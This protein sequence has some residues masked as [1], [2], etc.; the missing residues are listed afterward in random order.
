MLISLY[1]D[2]FDQLTP[3]VREKIF[4]CSKCIY[5]KQKFDDCDCNEVE[6]EKLDQRLSKWD[7]DDIYAHHC[8]QKIDAGKNDDY[9]GT[10]LIANKNWEQIANEIRKSKIVA[11]YRNKDI[12][13]SF[14]KSFTH[15]TSS[16]NDVAKWLKK[17]YPDHSFA[18]K[19]TTI[20]LKD[21]PSQTVNQV[22]LNLIYERAFK[23][24][25]KFQHGLLKWIGWNW[26]CERGKQISQEGYGKPTQ[27]R[28][29]LCV[30]EQRLFFT[31]NPRIFRYVAGGVRRFTYV[32]SGKM[33]DDKVWLFERGDVRIVADVFGYGISVE[34]GVT[35]AESLALPLIHNVCEMTVWIPFFD[36]TDHDDKECQTNVT[37]F[38]IRLKKYAQRGWADIEV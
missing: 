32:R 8:L 7:K 14:A 35:K 23:K 9:F 16:I 29:G 5:C 18:I 21:R 30:Y 10:F 13:R 20:P 37:A 3:E 36:E 12:A 6:F 11:R 26:L 27:F 33:R 2:Q 15:V 19:T 25:E 28:H 38:C 24:G 34:C 22:E 31:P 4:A 1:S 17:H